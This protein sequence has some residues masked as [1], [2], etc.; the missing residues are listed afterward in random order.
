[1]A[2]GRKGTGMTD[3]ADAA[4]LR[5]WQEEWTDIGW[6]PVILTLEDAKQHP[7]YEEF[8]TKLE[9]VPLWGRSKKKSSMNRE[10]NQLCY[11]R[12][13]AMAAVGGGFMSDY[14]VLPLKQMVSEVGPDFTVYSATPGGKGVPCLMGGQAHDW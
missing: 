13:L 4:M 11:I 1:M 2:T 12:H 5:V 6:D 7:R 3:E 8:A 10:Y 14:D 9:N